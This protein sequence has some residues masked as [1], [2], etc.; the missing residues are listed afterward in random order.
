MFIDLNARWQ[1]LMFDDDLFE[2]HRQDE[3][4]QRYGIVAMCTVDCVITT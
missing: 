3:Q 1:V 4:E 2:P